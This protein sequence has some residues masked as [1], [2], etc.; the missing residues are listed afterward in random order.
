MF[1]LIARVLWRWEPLGFNDFIG[2]RCFQ[3]AIYVMNSIVMF[4]IQEVPH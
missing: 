3:K 1:P 2:F 4:S